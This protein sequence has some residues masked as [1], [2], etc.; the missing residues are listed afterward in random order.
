MIKISK[1]TF[2]GPP[3]E[4]GT[5]GLHGFPGISGSPG[6]PGEPGPAGPPGKGHLVDSA[7]KSA[8]Y[9]CSSVPYLILF[10]SQR[11][12]DCICIMSKQT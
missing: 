5:P 6:Y 3:G 4:I 8:K 2:Q 7:M 1:R 11:W 9:S 10:H 12:Q